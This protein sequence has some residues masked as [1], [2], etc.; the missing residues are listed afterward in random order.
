MIW[1][2]PCQVFLTERGNIMKDNRVN[3]LIIRDIQSA[4]TNITDMVKVLDVRTRA[5]SINGQIVVTAKNFARNLGIQWGGRFFADAVHGNTSGYQFPNNYAINAT[6]G[7]DA[8]SSKY[9]VN[10]PA[11]NQYL[12]MTFG[13]V[14]D[15]LRLNI[16]LSAAEN[17]GLSKD[18]IE[19][20]HHDFE[21]RIGH[22]IQR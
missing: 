14:M 22:N 6:T 16:A 10:F 17:E 3:A 15:T 1:K 11:G 21:Q 19:T 18:H 2:K 13:N 20:D 5:V 7:T 12:A 9:A 8:D 4:L